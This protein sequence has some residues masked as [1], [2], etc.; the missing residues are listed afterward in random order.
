MKCKRS[1]GGHAIDHHSLQVMR[2]QAIKAMHEGQPAASVA[3][4]F[5]VDMR[6]VHR[7]MTDFI[8]V[9]QNPPLLAMPWHVISPSPSSLGLMER[10]ISHSAPLAE[11]L[12]PPVALLCALDPKV[13]AMPNI[14]IK[15]APSG[16]WTLRDKASR[17][18]LLPTASGLNAS[19]SLSI[20]E[21]SD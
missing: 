14:T 10:S 20:G 3:A 16:R 7:G 9:E 11:H 8:N 21:K 2:Q 6:S 18:H 1:S 4:A 19:F 15:A 5:G 17:Q 12:S 13:L